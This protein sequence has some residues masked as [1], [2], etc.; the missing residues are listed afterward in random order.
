MTLQDAY[1]S[2]DRLLAFLE[3][4]IVSMEIAKSNEVSG[5]DGA[6]YLVDHEA[7]SGPFTMKDWQIGSQYQI[8]AVE[9]YWQGWPAMVIWRVSSGRRPRMLVTQTGLLSG[10]FDVADTIFRQRH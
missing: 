10:D 2:F 6:A 1:G 3:Q 7:G 4:P 9:D 5:D 8:S